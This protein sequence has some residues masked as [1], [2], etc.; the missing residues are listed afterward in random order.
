[1]S[2]KAKDSD[3]K[4]KMRKILLITGF[5]ITG[6]QLIA[7]IVLMVIMGAVKIIPK[8]YVVLLD[9]LLVLFFLIFLIA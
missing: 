8:D 1:M 5:A 2:T 6:L 3:N 4:N 9:I 7:S